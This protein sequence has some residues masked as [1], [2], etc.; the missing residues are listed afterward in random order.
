MTIG[1]LVIL[2][3]QT[4][5]A[6]GAGLTVFRCVELHGL[7]AA[8]GRSFGDQ[9][10]ASSTCRAITAAMVTLATMIDIGRCIMAGT[11]AVDKSETLA[12]YAFKTIATG[13]AACTAVIDVGLGIDAGTVAALQSIHAS[14]G[15]IDACTAFTTV[16]VVI[17][18]MRRSIGFACRVGAIVVKMGIA[19]T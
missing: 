11:I 6:G 5:G 17:T 3:N 1:A 18:A 8:I 4:V 7:I 15:A 14:T 2:A 19:N 16:C 9:T 12:A 10:F 13:I